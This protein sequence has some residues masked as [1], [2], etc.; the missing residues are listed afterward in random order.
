MSPCPVALHGWSGQPRGAVGSRPKPWT[1][2]SAVSLTG[3]IQ[4]CSLWK[5]LGRP[6]AAQDCIHGSS[7]GGGICGDSSA[8]L[9]CG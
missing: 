8:C 4:W 3:A 2:C 5:S 1:D 6:R 7:A 9:F